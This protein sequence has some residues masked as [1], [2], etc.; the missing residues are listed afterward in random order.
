MNPQSPADRPAPALHPFGQLLALRQREADGVRFTITTDWL[1]GRTT[2]GG[3]IAA[4]GVQAMLDCSEG[5]S[6]PLR[7]LQTNFVGPVGAGETTVKVQQLRAGKNTRQMQATVLQR[8]AS[9]AEAVAAVLL[10]TF[11]AARSSTLPA[12]LP[13]APAIAVGPEQ[14]IR[15]PQIE[16][17]T[18]AFIRHFDLRWAE[19]APPYTGGQ[20]WDTSMYLRLR[21][22]DG[23]HP[24]V[25]IV[26][27][28]DVPPTP[29][30]GQLRSPAPASSVT[31]ALEL[32]PTAAIEPGAPW[33]I[34]MDTLAAADGYINQRGRLWTPAGELAALAYQVVAVYA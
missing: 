5:T 33:R 1:Q 3:L 12:L 14:A 29:A 30:I 34:D 22:D 16:G 10:A 17:V 27:L 25:L 26:L 6:M 7:A 15:F 19:G 11:G 9:G 21:D 20:G 4:L 23:V 24:E 18:P 32:R 31:W 28:A 13:R 2:F 8:G